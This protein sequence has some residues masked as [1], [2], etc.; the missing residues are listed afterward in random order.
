MRAWTFYVFSSFL[1][2]I[3]ML[4][5]R[6]LNLKNVTAFCL[7]HCIH[8]GSTLWVFSGGRAPCCPSSLLQSL[9]L[10]NSEC[11]RLSLSH[12]NFGQFLKMPCYGVESLVSILISKNCGPLAMSLSLLQLRHPLIANWI[13]L[14]DQISVGSPP[15]LLFLR[16]I[17]F[18]VS[19]WMKSAT[20]S[21]ATTPV[22]GPGFQEPCDNSFPCTLVLWGRVMRRQRPLLQ[23]LDKCLHRG[24]QLLSVF[25]QTLT[26]LRK[27]IRNLCSF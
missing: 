8:G 17:L 12:K 4:L 13:S 27:V 10:F 15:L 20:K 5:C 3:D 14:W 21:L 23:H 7:C 26:F 9:V 11:Q 6:S 2:F 25:S 22:L 24:H 19:S 1:I 16:K 18:L